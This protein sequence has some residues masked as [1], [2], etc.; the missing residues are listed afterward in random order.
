ML[1]ARR[2]FLIGSAALLCAPAI[3]Q[4]SNLMPVRAIDRL[5]GWDLVWHDIDGNVSIGMIGTIDNQKFLHWE[6]RLAV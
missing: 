1:I 4:A 2:R 5:D 3:V 6:L